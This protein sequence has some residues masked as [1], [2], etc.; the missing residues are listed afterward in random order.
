MHA[1]RAA[2]APP[3]EKASLKRLHHHQDD[4]ADHQ[5]GRHLVGDA[6]EPCRPHVGIRREIALCDHSDTMGDR[7][8]TASVGVAEVRPAP[9]FQYLYRIA[10]EAL[11]DAKRA[12]RNRINV[13]RVPPRGD[14]APDAGDRGIAYPA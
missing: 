4:D 3:L 6:V 10:D 11:Y 9:D 14:G 8:V 2:Q 7:P 5:Q 13:Q 1:A 12:G